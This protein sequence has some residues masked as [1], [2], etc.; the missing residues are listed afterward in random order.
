[1]C[2]L[3]ENSALFA[4][5]FFYRKERKVN[6]QRTQRN[7]F[8]QMK[9]NLQ[10]IFFFFC[11]TLGVSAQIKFQRTYGEAMYDEGRS[12]KQ[13]FDGGY[14]IAGSTSSFGNGASDVLLIKTDS[15]G[16]QQ[17]LKTYGGANIDRGYDVAQL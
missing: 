15:L 8:L 7:I 11:F 12:V 4:V 1:L 16:N 6:S 9:K 14:I 5:N 13:T 10:L 2:E 17:F 3:C